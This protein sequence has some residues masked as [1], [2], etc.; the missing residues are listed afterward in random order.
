MVDFRFGN[1]LDYGFEE[2]FCLGDFRHNRLVANY[3]LNKI[4]LKKV[5]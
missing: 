1:Y 5:N 2:K 4:I 3:I